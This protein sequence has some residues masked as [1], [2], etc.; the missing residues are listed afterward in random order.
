MA[1]IYTRTGDDGTTGLLGGGRVPKTHPR[2]V[3]SGDID[4]LNAILALARTKCGKPVREVL[5]GIHK[6]LWLVMGELATPKGVKPVGDVVPESRPGEFEKTIDRFTD[7]LPPLAGFVV[8]GNTE[9]AAMLHVA[10]TVCRR[11]ERSVLR[12]RETETIRSTVV[13]YLNRLSDLLFTLA[14]AEDH[15]RPVKA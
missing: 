1:K 13:T 2:I 3:A 12:L 7:M 11:A 8:P 4:E 10:R 14:R 6:D 9:A 5:D 15:E